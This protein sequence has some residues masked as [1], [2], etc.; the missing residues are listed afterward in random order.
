M[1]LRWASLLFSLFLSVARS[2]GPLLED[3][4]EGQGIECER[5]VVTEQSLGVYEDVLGLRPC[6][7]ILWFISGPGSSNLDR[8]NDGSK[9]SFHLDFHFGFCNFPRSF[10]RHSLLI[11]EAGR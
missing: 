9:F 1:V 4:I 11:H 10:S 8:S 7:C 6:V 2:R 3:G 5:V